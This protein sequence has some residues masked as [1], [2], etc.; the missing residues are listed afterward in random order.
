MI[1][2][3]DIIQQ[4]PPKLHNFPKAMLREYLQYK[5]LA[6]I[7]SSPIAQKLCFI[8]WTALRIGYNSQR[9]SEDIDFDNRWLT[10]EEFK[11]LT[12]IIE[13]DLSLEWYEVEIRHIYKWAFHCSIKIP[14]ILFENNLASMATEKLLIKI[15]TTPQGYA[16]RKDTL[17][18]QRFGIVAPYKIVPKDILLSM[19]FSAFFSRL[20]WRDM[21]D[22]VY[23]LGMWV[24]PHRWFCKH[25]FNIGDAITLKRAIKK[26]ISELNLIALQKDV[27][28]F[29]FDSNDQSVALFD[30]IIDQTVF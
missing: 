5:I 29:L 23:L 14:K 24:K 10:K 20:K 15:D 26:R 18:L 4:F 13:Y 25:A 12:K 2:L 22:I 17:V 11:R 1:S 8:W 21:F 3:Q 27:Q 19:K 6:S 9:F 28:P 16:Y 7:F 30:K